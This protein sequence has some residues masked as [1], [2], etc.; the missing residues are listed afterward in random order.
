MT[1]VFNKNDYK[2]VEYQEDD[3]SA[4]INRNGDYM[5]GALSS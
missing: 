2:N 4:F 1:T 3:D 5:N